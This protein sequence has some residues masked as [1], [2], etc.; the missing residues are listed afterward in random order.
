MG[1]RFYTKI[2]AGNCAS[3]GVM[4]LPVTPGSTS[5]HFAGK[6]ETTKHGPSGTLGHIQLSTVRQERTRPMG[7]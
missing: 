4:S 1:V 3:G 7:R 6:L 5:E 2:K